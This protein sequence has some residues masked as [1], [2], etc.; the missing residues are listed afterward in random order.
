MKCA[1]AGIERNLQLCAVIATP[2]QIPFVVSLRCPWMDKCRERMD[3]Q[4]RL[5]P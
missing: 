2:Q 4:E 3:A 1:P 5:E